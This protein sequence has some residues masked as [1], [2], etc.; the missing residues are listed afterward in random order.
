MLMSLL[1]RPA[2][3]FWC[4]CLCIGTE[5]PDDVQDGSDL[6]VV[7]RAFQ[8]WACAVGSG[9]RFYESLSPVLP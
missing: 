4:D 3:R 7:R 9:L 1:G 6:E 8:T 2:F 5:W